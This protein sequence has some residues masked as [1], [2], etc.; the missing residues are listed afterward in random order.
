MEWPGNGIYPG[1]LVSNS[2]PS[3]II[4]SWHLD[5]W[6]Q[7]SHQFNRASAQEKKLLLPAA[8]AVV[9]A[10]WWM[11][12]EG[13]CAPTLL[14]YIYIFTLMYVLI[15]SLI[16][17]EFLYR[18]ENHPDLYFVHTH[19]HIYIYAHIHAYYIYI[20]MC[21]CVVLKDLHLS[22]FKTSTFM[23]MTICI[24]LRHFPQRQDKSIQKPAPKLIAFG[25]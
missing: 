17:D 16:D 15:L 21:I 3:M 24:R 11:G 14:Y 23:W 10:L 22:L 13:F 12:C 25:P 20:C 7:S 6:E 9:A 18:Y 8:T 1:N 4:I 19:I 5:P 2:K